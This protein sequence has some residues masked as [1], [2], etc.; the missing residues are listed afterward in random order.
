MYSGDGGR[1][2]SVS[3]RPGLYIK[4][5]E[6]Q[7]YVEGPSSKQTNKLQNGENKNNTTI[8]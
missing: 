4:F 1:G 3:S 2:I 5:Q 8:I 6:R 7:G